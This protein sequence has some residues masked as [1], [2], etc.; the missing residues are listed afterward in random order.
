[1][2]AARCSTALKRVSFVSYAR[3]RRHFSTIKS[4]DPRFAPL[5]AFQERHIGPNEQ[6]VG[7]MLGKVGYPSMDA[8]IADT[9][10]PKIR[11]STTSVSNETIPVLSESELHGRAK[12]LGGQNLSFKS[13][14]GMG[15]HHAV[16]P[17]VILRNVRAICSLPIIPSFNSAIVHG[18]PAMVYT[19][20]ALSA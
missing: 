1:M 2:A 6:E 16:V 10:P 18:K 11:V 12:E 15:Y 3:P 5:D 17:P 8:F 13:Y 14:I 20:Y 9:V 4:S 19:L 7:Y